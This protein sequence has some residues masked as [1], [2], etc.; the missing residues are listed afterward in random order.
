VGHKKSITLD[1]SDEKSGNIGV[2]I[3]SK[4]PTS[5]FTAWIQTCN[6]SASWKPYWKTLIIALKAFPGA[7]VAETPFRS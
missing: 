5:E 2:V 4:A 1:L 3:A 7:R 6:T